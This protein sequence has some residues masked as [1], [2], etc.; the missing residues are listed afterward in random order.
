[1]ANNRQRLPKTSS[2]IDVAKLKGKAVASNYWNELNEKLPH[3]KVVDTYGHLA[4][5]TKIDFISY[6]R[7]EWMEHVVKRKKLKLKLNNT[8]VKQ[9]LTREDC[10]LD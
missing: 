5:W 10:I 3:Q 4:S 1:M 6:E 8:I 2:R 7:K 9:V